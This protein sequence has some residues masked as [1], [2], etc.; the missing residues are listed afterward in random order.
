MSGENWA[1][2]LECDGNEIY[3]PCVKPKIRYGHGSAAKNPWLSQR[4]LERER[5]CRA[6]TMETYARKIWIKR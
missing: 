2:G 1:G 3:W 4:S 5:Y 6:G